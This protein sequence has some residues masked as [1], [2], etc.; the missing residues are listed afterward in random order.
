MLQRG[1]MKKG[2]PKKHNK[3]SIPEAL[4]TSKH[5]L[6]AL[7]GPFEEVYQRSRSH[8]NKPGVLH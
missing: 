2:V 8:E 7:V 3:L 6:I 4:E 5:R 1:V